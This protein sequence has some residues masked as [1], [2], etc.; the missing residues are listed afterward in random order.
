VCTETEIGHAETRSLDCHAS[1]AGCGTLVMA[2][3]GDEAAVAQAVEAFR[4]AMLMT[5]RIQFK[6][7]TAD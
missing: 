4:N 2:Q 3:S 5:D 6:A 1:I 7:L